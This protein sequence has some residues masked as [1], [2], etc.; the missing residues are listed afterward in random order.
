MPRDVQVVRHGHEVH[1]A[2]PLAV[3]EQRALDAVGAGQQR[4]LGRGH[5]HALVVVRVERDQDPVA[6][7]EP[8]AEPLDHVGIVVGRAALDGGGQIQDHRLLG[9]ALPH[10]LEDRLADLRRRNRGRC[11]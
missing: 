5:G 9:V 3:A 8:A 1:V 7:R 2:G 11:R 4:Q 6:L 10:A